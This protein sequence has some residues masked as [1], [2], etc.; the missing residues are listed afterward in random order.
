MDYILEIIQTYTLEVILGLCGLFILSLLINLITFISFNKKINRYKS[1]VERT[2]N[3]SLEKT[4]FNISQDIVNMKEKD[5]ELSETIANLKNNLSFAIQHVGFIR[6]NAFENIGSKLSFSLALL[7]GNKDGII[8]TSIYSNGETISY[9]KD[10]KKGESDISLSAEEL[11]A[12][13][14]S[15]S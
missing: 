9:A 12:L 2:S 7:D 6:Y 14:R 15:L 4:V 13:D 1:Q 8:Y 5:L 10:I 3:S 11:I